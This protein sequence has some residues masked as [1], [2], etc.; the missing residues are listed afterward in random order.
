VFIL[1]KAHAQIWRIDELIE[2]FCS[3]K[4]PRKLM[5]FSHQFAIAPKW[6]MTQV[7][8]RTRFFLVSNDTICLLPFSSLS[9]T[10]PERSFY[11]SRLYLKAVRL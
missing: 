11:A 6:D 8:S 10:I 5:S 7:I 9:P 3:Q 2:E 4:V 1:A